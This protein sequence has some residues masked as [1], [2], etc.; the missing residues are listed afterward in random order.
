MNS[1]QSRAWARVFKVGAAILKG[2][3][4]REA[5]I[6]FGGNENVTEISTGHQFEDRNYLET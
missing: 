6:T 4:K 5:A 3:F 2:N 1:G